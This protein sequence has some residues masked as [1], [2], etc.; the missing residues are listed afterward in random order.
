MDNLFIHLFLEQIS[1][2]LGSAPDPVAVF[3]IVVCMDS[4][5]MF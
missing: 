2:S 1:L 3:F 4:Y 5:E